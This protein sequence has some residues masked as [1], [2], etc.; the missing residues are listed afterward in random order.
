[1]VGLMQFFGSVDH[2]KDGMAVLNSDGFILGT[3][4]MS[5]NFEGLAITRGV[6]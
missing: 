6:V 2:H 4:L 1:M 3:K 5:S